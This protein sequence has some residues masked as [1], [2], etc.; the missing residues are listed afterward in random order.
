MPYSGAP[1]APAPCNSKPSSPPHGPPSAPRKKS[2]PA[3]GAP[4][5]TDVVNAT[6]SERNT[7]GAPVGKLPPINNSERG[8]PAPARGGESEGVPSVS[9]TPDGPVG[10]GLYPT[11]GVV[12]GVTQRPD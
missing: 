9:T 8:L 4:P 11:L 5:V 7:I 1:S 10:S 6:Q 12:C 2:L 3:H